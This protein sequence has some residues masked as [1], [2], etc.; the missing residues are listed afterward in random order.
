MTT[1]S[2]YKY[3]DDQ[4]WAEAFLDGKLRFSSLAYFRSIEDG[5]VRGDEHEGL[6]TYRPAG[7]LVVNN[8]TQGR[9]LV[10][11]Y[12]F[13]SAAKKAEEIFVLCLSRSLT[14]KLWEEFRAVICVE[15]LDIPALCNRIEA[16]LPPGAA[17]PG[18]PGQT[19]IGHPVE[20]YREAEPVGTRWALPGRIA[21]AKSIGYGRQAEYRLVF[22]LT[23]ALNFEQVDLALV[24]DGAA[25]TAQEVVT[26]DPHYSVTTQSLRDICQLHEPG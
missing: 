21:T 5:G 12:S 14:R 8:H 13:T 7:G 16:A 15:V 6:A 10:L 11:P 24:P 2:L 22:S 9:T 26:K 25:G 4:Q 17:F 20:Y 23:D 1:H 19:R 18:R 3:F